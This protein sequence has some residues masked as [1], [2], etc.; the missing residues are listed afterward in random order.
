VSPDP[1]R[2]HRLVAPESLFLSFSPPGDPAAP[3]GGQTLSVSTHADAVKW[4]SLRGEE[5][6]ARKEEA[7]TRIRTVLERLYP[8]LG[9][10]VAHEDVATPRTFRRFARRARVG[11]PPIGLR[12]SGFFAL[13]PSLGL[14]GFQLVGDTTFPGQGTLATAM[15]GALAAARLGAVRLL[16]DGRIS[17]AGPRSAETR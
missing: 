8:G 17:L 14:P 3:P 16:R 9:A 2:L 5:Y 7:R 1:R 12:N 6:A 4:T 11:G 15:S 10:E 13:D